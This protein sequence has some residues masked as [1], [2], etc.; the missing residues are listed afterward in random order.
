MPRGTEGIIG[1]RTLEADHAALA[2]LL[3]PGMKVLDVGCGTG[4]ITRGIARAV[5]PDGTACGIDVN[6]GLIA[7]AETDSSGHPNARF[8]VADIVDARW[9]AAFDVVT[10]ARVLQWLA[11]PAGALAAMTRAVRPGG[12]VAVLDYDHTLAEWDPVMPPSVRH[13]YQAFLD[14]RADAGLDNAIASHLPGL[15]EQAGLADVRE[16][17]QSE[18]TTAADPGYQRRIALWPDVIASRGHQVV[19]DGWLT[20]SDRALAEQ[21]IRHWIAESRPA[22]SLFLRSVTGTRPPR[23]GAS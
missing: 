23:S 14:W 12:T 21:E 8:E 18:V 6:A 20:E 13:F 16:S 7:T 17:D 22:Q 15:M 10:S 2:T 5:A 9:D 3:R 11:E 1:G 4:A 19:A